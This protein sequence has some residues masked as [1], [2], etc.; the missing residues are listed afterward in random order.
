MRVIKRIEVA[1]YKQ[2]K[3]VVPF[4]LSQEEA[5]KYRLIEIHMVDTDTQETTMF[6]NEYDKEALMPLLRK[7]RPYGFIDGA[8]QDDKSNLFIAVDHVSLQFIDMVDSVDEVRIP[9][10]SKLGDFAKSISTSFVGGGYTAVDSMHSLFEMHTNKINL[11][12]LF[13][14]ICSRPNGWHNGEFYL[15]SRRES[16]WNEKYEEYEPVFVCYR[17]TFEDIDEARHFIQ[18]GVMLHQN[19]MRPVVS[20][21]RKHEI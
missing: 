15:Y 20:D 13:Q 7:Y 17:V 9:A 6:T 4:Y 19:P 5:V 18:K 14:A 12:T 10:M 1:E 21:M 2:P 16:V 11:C 8:T 3:T